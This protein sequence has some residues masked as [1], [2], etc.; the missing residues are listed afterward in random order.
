MPKKQQEKI[1]WY[2]VGLVVLVLGWSLTE[3]YNNVIEG[4]KNLVAGQAKI[5][6]SVMDNFKEIS[7]LSARIAKVEP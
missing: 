1:A 4:Q 2:A 6:D 5:Q 3:V 7:G